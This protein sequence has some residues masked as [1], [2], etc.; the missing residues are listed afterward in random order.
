LRQLILRRVSR[1]VESDAAGGVEAFARKAAVAEKGANLIGER[2]QHG[3][4]LQTKMRN[5]REEFT[6]RLNLH[7]GTDGSDFLHLWIVFQDLFRI[8]AATRG[9]FEIADEGGSVS[10]PAGE[11]E[12]GKQI[13]RLKNVT[14]T[15]NQRAAKCRIKKMFL[16]YA[17]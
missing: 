16:R 17:P 7:E 6:I 2:L 4:S 8:P 12:R 9:D 5:R 11:C 10:W 13:Q 3:I 15:R 14:R 1:D